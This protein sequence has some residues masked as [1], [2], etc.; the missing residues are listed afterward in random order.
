M[1]EKLLYFLHEGRTDAMEHFI[2][3]LEASGQSQV[4]QLILCEFL[5]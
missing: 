1:V 5:I 3:S 2:S 4:A